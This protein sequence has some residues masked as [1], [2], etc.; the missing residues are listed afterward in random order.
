VGKVQENDERR[1][2]GTKKMT[3]EPE[4]ILNLWYV[5]DDL[6][7]IYSLRARCYVRSGTDEEKLAFLRSQAET[8][9]LVA[10]MF[11]VPERFHTTFHV[12]NETRKMAVVGMDSLAP[13]GGVQIL[14]EDAYQQLEK[15]L[16]ATTKL[17]IGRDPLVCITPL[18]SDDNN[19]LH[20][21]T[22]LRG[23]L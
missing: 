2:C 19:G 11:P 12:N 3:S 21:Q 10:D 23:K 20:P 22:K 6:G 17:T 7:M 14:F 8:D 4:I 18:L 1:R 16:P 5:Y 15:E 13:F 9:Y